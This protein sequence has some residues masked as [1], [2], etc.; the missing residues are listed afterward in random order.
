MNNCPYQSSLHLPEISL[1]QESSAMKRVD[2]GSFS[3]AKGFTLIELMITVAIIGILAAVAIPNYT[4]YVIRARIGE[5]TGNLTDMRI[6]AERFFQDRRTYVGMDCSTPTH[7]TSHF[8]FS[9]GVA[10]TATAYTLTATGAGQMSGF[11]FT[12]DQSNTRATS[13]VPSG[14][15]SSATC[16][17]LNRSGGC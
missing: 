8:T 14:W 5:A 9:C 7:T 3:R 6:R 1:G 16:W 17:V 12:V 4:E 10:A 2:S 11:T 13:A 15:T